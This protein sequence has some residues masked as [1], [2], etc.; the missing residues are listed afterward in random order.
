[1]K[2]RKFQL[3]ILKNLIKEEIK[4]LKKKNLFEDVAST[5]DSTVSSTVIGKLG[6]P[7]LK[8]YKADDG[9]G[10]T[11]DIISVDGYENFDLKGFDA[12]FNIKPPI[13]TKKS[14]KNQIIRINYAIE[15]TAKDPKYAQGV[16]DSMFFKLASNP[17]NKSIILELYYNFKLDAQYKQKYG[18]HYDFNKNFIIGELHGKNYTTEETLDII[19]PSTISYKGKVS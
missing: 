6:T 19:I 4:L 14:G 9:S 11:I 7:E 3:D 2:N 15:T 18:S 5:L 13:F 10:I 17:T 12:F 16:I 1:M 8:V